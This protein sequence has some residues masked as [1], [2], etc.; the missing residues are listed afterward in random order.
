MKLVGV[1]SRTQIDSDK[2]SNKEGPK[3]KVV[4]HIT[5]FS[6]LKNIFG[7]GYVANLSEGMFMVKK[8]K[9]VPWTYFISDFN[10]EEIFG[11]FYKK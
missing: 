10:G 3:F 11:T 5:I 2:E 6:Y 4:D 1:K 8:V 7:K 9:K